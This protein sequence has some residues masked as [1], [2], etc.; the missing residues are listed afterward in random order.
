M[1]AVVTTSIF[2]KQARRYHAPPAREMLTDGL[3]NQLTGLSAR[4]AAE[5][6]G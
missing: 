2:S 1:A 4:A 6:D 3:I 5:G